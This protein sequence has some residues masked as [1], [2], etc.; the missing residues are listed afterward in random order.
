MNTQEFLDRL[1]EANVY[2][3]TVNTFKRKGTDNISFMFYVWRVGDSQLVLGFKHELGEW[4]PM[5]DGWFYQSP[6]SLWSSTGLY[7]KSVDEFLV[8]ALIPLIVNEL[9]ARKWEPKCE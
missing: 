9:T 2:P 1:K 8:D 3:D 7:R 6:K 4:K 5:I